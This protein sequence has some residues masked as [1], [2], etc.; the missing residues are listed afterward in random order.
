[1]LDVINI[2]NRQTQIFLKL[3]TYNIFVRRGIYCSHLEYDGYDGPGLG[4]ELLVLDHQHAAGPLP[5][6]VLSVPQVPLIV[7]TQHLVFRAVNEM[8]QLEFQ[9]ITPTFAE[10]QAAKLHHDLLF[11][12]LR[13]ALGS[14]ISTTSRTFKSVVKG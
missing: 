12:E 14:R 2:F 3:E 4:D 1:M 7:I 8:I 10:L 11:R 5:G 13:T 6:E 9:V